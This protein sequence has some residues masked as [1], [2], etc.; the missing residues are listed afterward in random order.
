MK[1]S[2]P[3]KKF[4]DSVEKSSIGA[5]TNDSQDEDRKKIR[6]TDACIK[7]S[8]NKSEVVFESSSQEA[9]AFYSIPVGGDVIVELDGSFCVEVSQYLKTLKIGIQNVK[10][11][12]FICC[13]YGLS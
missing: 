2:I 1:M 13:F 11:Y 10:E 7:I 6:P 3:L 8:T 5:L 4:L 12:T 9:S